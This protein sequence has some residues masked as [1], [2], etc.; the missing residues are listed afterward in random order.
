MLSAQD[1]VSCYIPQFTLNE[2]SGPCRR[3]RHD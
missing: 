3:C 1:G 2:N